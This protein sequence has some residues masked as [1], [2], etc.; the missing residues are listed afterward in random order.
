[1]FNRANP[2]V[3]RKLTKEVLECW[4]ENAGFLNFADAEMKAYEHGID[5]VKML[6]P[7]SGMSIEDLLVNALRKPEDIR[8]IEMAYV[9]LPHNLSLRGE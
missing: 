2:V 1:M 9:D 4:A 6:N 3:I 5:P 7:Y 8:F